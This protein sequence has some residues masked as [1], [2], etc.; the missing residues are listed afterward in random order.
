MT[1]SLGFGLLVI[2]NN[3]ALDVGAG[4]R[5]VW[6]EAVVSLSRGLE[7]IAVGPVFLYVVRRIQ[8]TTLS[9]LPL[10]G[11]YVAAALLLHSATEVAHT[12]F[13]QSIGFGADLPFAQFYWSSWKNAGLFHLTSYC[14]VGAAVYGYDRQAEAVRLLKAQRE[15][16]VR[17]ARLESELARAQLHAL[18]MQV[19]PHFLFNA[20]SA[21][22]ALTKKDPARARHVL[23]DLGELLRLA[24]DTTD[25]E[26]PLRDELAILDRY[27]RIE[28]TRMGDRLRVD[29]DVDPG[30][31]DALVPPLLLQPLAENAVKHGLAPLEEG[32]SVAVRATRDGDALTITVADTGR[33]LAAAPS[34]MAEGGI[35]LE[36]VRR[37]LDRLYGG[38]GAL[39]LDGRSGGGLVAV[40][41]LPYRSSR[42][43]A[44]PEA[45]ALA[46]TLP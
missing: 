36:N 12:G 14:A 20:L 24:L 41:R 39:S 31:L 25:D 27:V 4:G 13:A 17:E 18:R 15:R 26:I 3:Y 29:V 10:V 46:P 21:A 7:W 43:L 22:A 34:T 6:L 8:S 28:K 40:V 35:G 38:A 37:R 1:G 19:H 30:L 23:V 32:G 42:T 45:S 2:A 5:F 11:A 9:G 44:P 16:E 33:G